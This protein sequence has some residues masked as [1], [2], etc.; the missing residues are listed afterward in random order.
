M[1]EAG[2]TTR[3]S[4]G[5]DG[6][7]RLRAA[8]AVALAAP[9]VLATAVLSDVGGLLLLATYGI[10]GL[11]LAIRRPGQPIAWLLL[12]MAIGLALGTA[13]VTAT[14]DALLAERLTPIEAFTTWANGVGWI[15]VFEGLIGIAL[16]FPSGRMPQ[17]PWRTVGRV[18]VA[19]SLVLVVL[20]AAGPI[21]NVTLPTYPSGVDV[22][23]P[24]ALPI[25][26]ESSILVGL[27]IP[28]W[29]TLFIA[30]GVVGASLVARFRASSGMER[31]QYRWLAW[32]LVLVGIGSLV[33]A[34]LT[35]VL[36]LDLGLLPALV[37]AVTYPAIPIAVVVAVLRYR[38]YEID[39]LVSR[40]LGWGIA[41][42]AVVAMF[43]VAVLGLQA[44]LTHVTQGETLAVAASTLLAFAAFQPVRA[45]VQGMVD[46]RF[47]R[48]RLE[49]E[50]QLAEYG[51]RLQH[52][53]DLRSLTRDV[54]AT[55]DATLRPSRAGL[56]IRPA[57]GRI[58]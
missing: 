16:V 51:E 18:V 10:P 53:V 5:V 58:P 2:M 40:T 9:V 50:R 42:A 37:V 1:A 15:F 47:D 48:P 25:F 43:V 19:V 13:R 22:P 3:K 12:L 36:V 41:T 29:I 33:W 45:R 8:A 17:S 24:Y 34:L 56:W 14:L 21:I 46:R 6:E 4:T 44:A 30:T 26:A 55:V 52:E 11:V 35:S 31:L 20:L 39:R 27:T 54:E 57:G 38:L 49:A 23:N 32:A 28:M 7:G